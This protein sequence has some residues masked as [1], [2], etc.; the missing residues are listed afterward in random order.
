[1]SRS[2]LTLIGSVLAAG[3]AVAGCSAAPPPAPAAPPAAAP[4]AA[5]PEHQGGHGAHEGHGSSSAVPAL[6]AVQSGPLGVVATDGGGHLMYRSDKDSAAPSASTCT[7][8]CTE[9]WLPVLVA[10]GQEPELLGV[11][12]AA[13]GR[14]ARPE[15]TS[16]LTLAGWPLYRHRDDVGGLQSA[17]HHGEDGTWFAVTPTG[18]KATAG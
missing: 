1:M 4:T 18:D 8:P 3:I 9:T 17:G 14:L 6:Y 11:D 2:A 7:G 10:P 5:A 13:V 12:K 16:Q 15:G